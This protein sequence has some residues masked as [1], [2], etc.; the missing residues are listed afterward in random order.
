M[1]GC[2]VNNLCLYLHLLRDIV[3]AIDRQKMFNADQL[4]YV[5]SVQ[6]NSGTYISTGTFEQ[7][8]VITLACAS[9]LAQLHRTF[10]PVF[11]VYFSRP[12]I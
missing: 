1:D 12:L 5:V 6:S 10:Y 4:Y 9:L 11:L 7:V 2:L 3:A 8:H